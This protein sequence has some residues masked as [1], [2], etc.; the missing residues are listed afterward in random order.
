MNKSTAVIADKVLV[1]KTV[2]AEDVSFELPEV[3]MQ[4]AD[5]SAMGTMSLPLVGLMDDMALTITKVGIDKNLKHMIKFK[6]TEFE[7]RWVQDVVSETG[8][9]SHKG[10]KAF[11]KC[12]PQKIPGISAEV[13]SGT[14]I[15]GS[16]TV[17][18]YQMFFDGEE[19]FLIDRLNH[20][21]RVNGTDYAQDIQNL[22]K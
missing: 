19:I 2:I 20:I 14:E 13:A 7:F 9:V 17:M 15:Q 8:E 22:L 18:R 12:F 1:G 5:V 21:L 10:V 11:V 6:K 4:T 3:V 16:Y